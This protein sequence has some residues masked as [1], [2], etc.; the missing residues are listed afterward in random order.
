M[1]AHPQIAYTLTPLATSRR[2]LQTL[3][4]YEAAKKSFS[5]FFKV[6]PE[7]LAVLRDESGDLI[8]G[9]REYVL[10]FSF[11]SGIFLEDVVN[12]PPPNHAFA[13]APLGMGRR[14]LETLAIEES[15]RKTFSGYFG[16]PE[17]EVCIWR[18]ENGSVIGARGEGVEG[19]GIFKRSS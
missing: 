12:F 2:L 3:T 17:D 9:K 4:T 6:S 19:L 7:D 5:Q 18:D 16:I 11:L 8:V 10:Q 14:L 15:A 1:P 13:L